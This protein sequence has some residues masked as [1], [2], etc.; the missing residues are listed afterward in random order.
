MFDPTVGRWL[1]EDPERFA[2]GDSNLYRYTGNDPTNLT[3]PTGLAAPPPPSVD[4]SSG[5]RFTFLSP[6]TPVPPGD[7]GGG[8]KGGLVKVTTG[9]DFVMTEPADQKVVQGAVAN[10]VAGLVGIG[11]IGGYGNFVG[12][13][14]RF[15]QPVRILLS[16]LE[17]VSNPNN[18][19]ID[20][21]GVRP[22]NKVN[23]IQFAYITAK[24]TRQ[25]QLIGTYWTKPIPGTRAGSAP[26]TVDTNNPKWFLDWIPAD[27]TPCLV[28]PTGNTTGYIQGSTLT[29]F[30]A[31]GADGIAQRVGTQNKGATIEVEIH[32]ATYILVN[33]RPAYVV[34]WVASSTLKPGAKQPSQVVYK[35]EGG[36][37][38]TNGQL[39]D[40]LLAVLAAT[41]P[42]WKRFVE[43]PPQGP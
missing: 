8:G 28:D 4:T 29:Y 10:G 9:V 13:L 5:F 32:F 38:V 16:L 1:Q 12:N 35:V 26:T 2:A 42:D 14:G 11:G 27:K 6:G 36:G 31:P 40:R 34:R 41:I 20:F 17:G 3:D 30:D 39:D 37:P 24:V 33:N 15:N 22:G 18:I 23:V 25:G 19:R 7:Y 43:P 21:N